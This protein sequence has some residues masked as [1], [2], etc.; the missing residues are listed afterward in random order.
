MK[1]L[2]E[3]NKKGITMIM[4]THDMNLITF[5][6]R[7]V[8]MRDGKI[9]SMR[10]VTEEERQERIDELD[11]QLSLG[12]DGRKTELSGNE[13]AV[14]SENE[15]NLAAGSASSASA[16]P[17]RMRV[18]IPKHSAVREPGDYDPI[19]FAD[20]SLTQAG[21]E[22]DCEVENIGQGQGEGKKR[23]RVTIHKRFPLEDNPYSNIRES[24]FDSSHRHHGGASTSS[25][26]SSSSSSTGNTTTSS[27]SSSS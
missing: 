25:S 26:S 22:I 5:G 27:S 9:G 16:Q 10:D 15:K 7:I 13:A 11:R 1:I 4:V 3:L 21:Y 17:E 2:L 23:K 18:I 14:V 24:S 19:S 8:F 20:P 12:R 6:T